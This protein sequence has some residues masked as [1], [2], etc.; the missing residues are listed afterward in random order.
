MHLYGVQTVGKSNG[1]PKSRNSE[2]E[3]DT[4]QTTRNM[5]FH[6]SETLNWTSICFHELDIRAAGRT[7]MVAGHATERLFVG[8]KRQDDRDGLLFTGGQSW[9]GKV[10]SNY[11]KMM[12]SN[13]LYGIAVL[14]R[15]N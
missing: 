3:R 14:L 4:R 8:S 9:V 7:G 2:R 1:S 5:Q 11:N 13:I 10:S 6:K 12:R 15:K